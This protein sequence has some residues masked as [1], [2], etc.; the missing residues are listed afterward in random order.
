[1]TSLL[2]YSATRR[3]TRCFYCER[4]IHVNNSADTCIYWHKQQIFERWCS[5]NL[6][7]TALYVLSSWSKDTF[8]QQPLCFTHFCF[9]VLM[10]LNCRFQLQSSWFHTLICTE[11]IG[12][13]VTHRSHKTP[14]PIFSTNIDSAYALL[15]KF[16][17]FLCSDSISLETNKGNGYCDTVKWWCSLCQSFTISFFWDGMVELLGIRY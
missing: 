4:M 11:K 17:K 8:S 7:I 2:T 9:T 10:S 6:R 16:D 12:F 13:Y 14:K 5:S 1:M 3:Y 15:I